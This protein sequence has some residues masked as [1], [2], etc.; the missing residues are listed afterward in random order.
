MKHQRRLIYIL[1]IMYFL[2]FLHCA[3]EALR[4]LNKNNSISIR[5]SRERSAQ[6]E[7]LGNT[8]FVPLFHNRTYSEMCYQQACLGLKHKK[9]INKQILN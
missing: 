9:G 1:G 4:N 8:T 6:H 5:Q 3:G 7:I 2:N